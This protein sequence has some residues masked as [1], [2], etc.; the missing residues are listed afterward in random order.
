M[1]S[2]VQPLLVVDD[3]ENNRDLLARRLQRAGFAVETASD[4][5]EA[6]ARID[7]KEYGLVLLDHM[8]PGMTG[9]DV[10]RLLRATYSPEQLPV[11]MVTALNDSEKIVEAIGLGANDYVTKPLD[12]AV[13]LARIRSQLSRKTAEAAL[14][15][16][17]QRYALAARGS[18]DGLWDWDVRTNQVY[19]SP[20]WKAAL[21]YAEGEIGDRL[22]E[23]LSRVPEPDRNGLWAAIEAHWHG[24]GSSPFEF[25]H[26]ILNRD[27]TYCWMLCR[28]LAVRDAGGL[29]VR[30]A[31]SSTDITLRKAYDSLT[32]LPNRLLFDDLL[33]RTLDRHRSL[34]GGLFAVYFLD[35]DRFK[36][37]N[38]SLGHAAGDQ[39]LKA[40]AERLRTRIEAMPEGSG[41]V[42]A[43]L[44][45]DEFA[46]LLEGI[47]SPEAAGAIADRLLESLRQP[48]TLEGREVF[49][50]ASIGIA[51]SPL[52][53]GEAAEMLRD[54]D[55]AMYAAKAGGKS[56][57]AS[58]DA[59]MRDRVVARLELEND[60]Q[61]AL[62][63][64]ELEVYY[65]PK[66]ELSSRRICGFEALVRWNH[67][68]RGLVMPADFI[69]VAEDSGLIVP[70]GRFVLEHS[71]ER[72]RDWNKQFGAEYPL[73]IS[74]NVSARQF[75]D[76]GLIE[77]VR[78]AIEA[79]GIQPQWLDLE[80]TESVFFHD[81]K[82]ALAAF[83][84]LK[85]I[86]VGLK[87]DDFG[88]GYSCLSYLC[89]FPFDAVK[90]DRSFVN[91]VE[92]DPA[93]QEMVK[94]ILAMAHELDM[95]VVAEG[96]EEEGQASVLDRMGCEYGQGYFFGKPTPVAEAEALLKKLNT[97][98]KPP[99]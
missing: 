89:Q 46:I 76:A 41:G 30:M 28:G 94:T 84:A 60:L 18:N 71:C 81:A 67:P 39:L 63:N 64:G 51:F 68:K 96:I 36:L 73:K 55:T 8:M 12:Y 65:Q 16:S 62:K 66:V 52:G 54:A 20:R 19:Y 53:Y 78:E 23:W 61:A 33:R 3:E 49:C 24:D 82:Q 10:L 77:A 40:V 87:M 42:V 98:G 70:L 14:R 6:L 5:P 99:V 75:E 88:T 29:V 95:N 44:G 59:A 26:R 15:E 38:D 43:R 21:G 22:E 72:I 93:N 7:Q 47:A 57:W 48:V 37:V 92:Q 27:G 17:E 25:E 35:L 11:I 83:Q 50:T 86:G 79:T 56:R 4:G 74:V 34:V 32:G 80:I 45:G 69:P 58:F 90:I 97:G 31:G 13:A 9:I 2:T 1:N 85:E 91:A